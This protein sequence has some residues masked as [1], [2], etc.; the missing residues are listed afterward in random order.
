VI[1]PIGK[2]FYNIVLQVVCGADKI[3]GNYYL[4]QPRGVHDG[5]QF[6]RRNLYAQLRFQEIFQEPI[7]TF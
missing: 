3:F 4:N 7:I 2:K 5:G 6:K 1:I